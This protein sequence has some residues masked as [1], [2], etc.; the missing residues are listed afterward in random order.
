[1]TTKN[2][3]IYPHIKFHNEDGGT[4]VQY[5]FAKLLDEKGI[6]IRIYPSHGYIDCP[7]FNKY[8]NNEFQIDDNCVVIYCEGVDGNPLNAKF[9]VR[10]MLS[11]LGQNVPS[12]LNNWGKNELVYHFNS[13][14]KFKENPHKV[15]NI[16][17]TLTPIYL[18]PEVKNNLLPDRNG[19]CHTFRKY[20]IHINGIHSLYHPPSSIE[21]TRRTKNEEIIRIFNECQFF[22][23]YDPLTFLSCMAAIC[24]CISI[25]Y[26]IQGKNKLEWLH[27]TAISEY[28]EYKKIDNIYGFAYGIEDINWAIQTIHLVKEQFDDFLLYCKQKAI[29]TF[30]EDVNNFD[31]MQN[32]I[33]NVY[34]K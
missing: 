33:E 14:L 4:T 15:G 12:Y 21:I 17:K 29:K 7:I 28:L 9:V 5:Y 20:T 23:S 1:M 24:G 8:Y 11:E 3:L 2:I 10:W 18:N 27:M 6:M 32:T 26:P 25:V 31:N 34:Y 16:Y 13:E 22:V 19:C 30:I